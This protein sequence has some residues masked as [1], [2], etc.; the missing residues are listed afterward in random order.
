MLKAK[1]KVVSLLTACLTL[2]FAFVLG[3]TTLLAPTPVTTA[4][5]AEFV[6]ELTLSTTAVSGTSYKDW[7]GKTAT[8]SAV[9]A[10]NSA[11]GNESI[12]LRSN[13]SN[14]GIVTTASGG[15]AKKVVVEWNSNTASGRT[16]NIYGKNTAY[17]APTDLYSNSAS[18]L[19]T[20][21]GTIK[22]GTS[23]ELEITGDYTYIGMRSN[24]GA[25]YLTSISITW[26]DGQSPDVPT[27]EHTSMTP[28]IIG[29]TKK[30]WTCDNADCD[31]TY[32]Q[33]LVT[34]NYPA[35]VTFNGEASTWVDEG[36]S[37]TPPTTDAPE[38]YVFAGWSETEIAEPTEDEPTFF[39][40]KDKIDEAKTLY[41]VYRN[42]G[43]A[44]GWNLVTDKSTLE[45]GNIVTIVCPTKNVAI[46]KKSG[47]YF[48][49]ISIENNSFDGAL[50]LTLTKNSDE[51]YSF[52]SAADEAY[53]ALTS[54]ANALHTNTSINTNSSWSVTIEGGSTTIL[55]KEFNTRKLQYNS[56]SPR[57][58]C[59]TSA[60]TAVALYKYTE[61]EA[62]TYRSSF[63]GACMHSN[64]TTTTVDATC[65]EDG[66]TTVTC[67]DC[68]ETIGEPVKIPATGHGE[69]TTTTVD[70]TCTE[71]GST[72]VTCND[73]SAVL[74]TTPI[75]ALEHNITDGT[76]VSNEDG[77]HSTTGTCSR[78]GEA[79]E[80]VTEPCDFERAVDTPKYTCTVCGYFYTVNEYTVDYV[81]PAGIPNV[82]DAV[83]EENN[84]TILKPAENKL[85]YTFVGW[86][87]SE[88]SEDTTECP[89]I[90]AAG[91]EYTV[92]EDVTLYAL[93]SY[94]TGSGNYVKV[95]KAPADWSGTY[96]IVYEDGNVA[97]N[98]SLATLDA[99]NNTADVTISN[100][101]IEGTAAMNA[102][103]FTFAKVADGYS[104]Q[105]ATGQ[106]IGRTANSNG[107]NVG[108]TAY[109]H[110]FA[111][112]TS[113][114]TTITSSGGATLKFNKSSDQMRFRY[115]KSGQQAIQLYALDGKTYYSTNFDCTSDIDGA[116]A[117][118]D[119]EI[120]LNYYVELADSLVASTKMQ[121]VV[122]DNMYEV[123]PEQDGERYKF[124]LLIP[125]QY[126]ATEITATLLCN[127]KVA[128]QLNDYSI[129]K[130]VQNLL[131]THSDDTEL[132][133]FLT[134]M[135]YYGNAAQ[136]HQGYDVE[137]LATKDVTGMATESTAVP[138]EATDKMSLV[139]AD[140]E[141]CTA[142]FEGANVWFDSVNKL[143]VRISTTD[144]V[145]LKV[146]GVEVA[147]TGTTIY[148]DGILA[149]AFGDK[150]TFEL[151]QNGVLQQ[152]LQYSIFSYAYSK[153]NN[154]TMGE[155]ALALYR[156]GVA[157]KAY[158]LAN[159]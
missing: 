132:V 55:N 131:T 84:V 105:A 57:F 148:T 126:M 22:C 40:D 102:I 95:T 82:P 98:S 32:N 56:G 75:E 108:N 35:S 67:N 136:K 36:D 10:G 93:Y 125:P 20:K 135:L 43:E 33:F 69:T 130:Y 153:Q 26:D 39:T 66:S 92:T 128:D 155:L 58:A 103:A 159:A 109:S 97:F 140:K 144:N 53:L 5:A 104:I 99:T 28:E 101:I 152:T 6:D 37:I 42:E 113:G 9:Y 17:S 13:N 139:T 21:I 59:Y 23:T 31:Y 27:C 7:S 96:L 64:T 86:V 74:S 38:G 94:S 8:S 12:Q 2:L 52:Y 45:T 112:D 78:C 90:L 137:N 62:L 87:E 91:S 18:T 1:R 54:S 50:K 11:G 71:A 106:Y 147:V 76:P 122:D 80:T 4:N 143:C 83:V 117:E 115:Y 89:E 142:W 133:N 30:V 119:A 68:G 24:S 107:L 81:V 129:K 114:N 34:Y 77:T 116:N 15:K 134:A 110:T 88:L 145:T 111:V 16:L 157:A 47:S 73:C 123:A 151:Y 127:G 121:F 60:Q 46:N 25:M 48:T 156:Y 72:T 70:A 65:T 14:S 118:V 63:E 19:G 61:G 138:Q 49:H 158:A 85:G 79:G 29:D 3:F 100:D 149:T 150:V 154:A 120:T 141:N 44:G 146:N 124:S 41:A 51:T